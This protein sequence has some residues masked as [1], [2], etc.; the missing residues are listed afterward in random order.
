MPR[1]GGA[2]GD[3]AGR[4]LLTDQAHIDSFDAS[5]MSQYGVHANADDMIRHH[6]R[7]YAPALRRA[8]LTVID[9]DAT[10][11]FKADGDWTAK[12]AK[13][14]GLSDSDK[15]LDVAV[16]G[17]ALVAVVENE[18][19]YTRKEV[20]PANDSYVEPTLS[21]VEA[22]DR[23]ELEG[24]RLF[25]EQS[26]ALRADA[27]LQLAEYKAELDAHMTERLAQI[28]E[29]ADKAVASALD[30]AAK[31]TAAKPG[32]KAKA[33]PRKSSAKARAP[34]KSAVKPAAKTPDT[35]ASPSGATGSDEDNK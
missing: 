13:V 23:A 4:G 9:E 26:R 32:T 16:R 33:A 11:A 3:D 34:R 29:E 31:K 21:P 6:Q 2:Q 20:G 1:G 10:K 7:S 30:D 8:N 5:L 24:S 14:L 28:K 15:V 25:S 22:A 27:E 12:A 19:G 35:K 17:N 18:N